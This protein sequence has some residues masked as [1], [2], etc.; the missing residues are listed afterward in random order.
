VGVSD[1]AL[2]VFPCGGSVGDGGVE[3]LPHELC[4]ARV[5]ATARIGLAACWRLCR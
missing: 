1:S 3:D 2:V 5:E 4:G